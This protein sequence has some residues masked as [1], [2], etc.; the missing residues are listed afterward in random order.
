MNPSRD[1]LEESARR[2]LAAARDPRKAAAVAAAG[3]A[4]VAARLGI[5]RLRNG[6][7]PPFDSDAYRLLA[8]EPVGPGIE[9]VIVARIDDAIAQLRGEAGT[10]AAEAV[11]EARKDIKKIRSALRLVRDEIGDEDW[12]REN[13]HY[14]DC[15]R[16]LSGFRDAEILVESLDG[17][18]ERFGSAA[19]E[20]SERLRRELD[21]ENRAAHDDGVVERAMATVAAELEA[22]RP[23]IDALSLD[24]DGWDLIAPGLHRS[25]RRGRDRL[26]AVEKEASVTNLHEL[27]KRVKDLW[28]QLRLIRDADSAMLGTLADHAH[29]LSDHLGDDHDLALLRE[30]IQRRPAAF[31]DAAELRHLLEE[32][33]QRRGELQFAALSLSRRIY[34]EKPKK[35]TRRLEKRWEAW[36]ER[37]P[38]VAA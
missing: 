31:D 13:D 9:R 33:D 22:G 32:V 26:K 35:F 27:R 29:D 4:A 3:G 19:R 38:P 11:H 30:Q 37:K 24:G 23:R 17:L 36:R 10:G 14:R 21:H 1:Q 18:A 16:Q 34:D 7:P 2:A 20:R 8:G 28:Y 25:Y 6:G 5:N 12:R 15:G